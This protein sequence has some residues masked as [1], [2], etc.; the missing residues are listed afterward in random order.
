MLDRYGF[1]LNCGHPTGRS[2][3]SHK[4]PKA[5]VSN[6]KKI[7]LYTRSTVQEHRRITSS[8]RSNRRHKQCREWRV[9]TL[10]EANQEQHVPKDLADEALTANRTLDGT[11][12]CLLGLVIIQSFHPML[13][14]FPKR[15]GDITWAEFLTAFVGGLWLANIAVL[16]RTTLKERSRCCTAVDAESVPRLVD[17]NLTFPARVATAHR[18]R[19]RPHSEVFGSGASRPALRIASQAC[20]SS[21]W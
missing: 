14:V 2:L 18:Q 13:D 9:V 5:A 19:S 11:T 16:W 7:D 21:V 1:T 12:R 4:V 17:L 3:Y 8:R 20:Q 6:C 15:P 10:R